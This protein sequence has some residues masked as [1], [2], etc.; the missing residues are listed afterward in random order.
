METDD[1]DAG[2]PPELTSELETDERRPDPIS[3]LLFRMLYFVCY[4]LARYIVLNPVRARMVERPEDYR[5]SSYRATV[6]LKAA[7]ESQN[8]SE[9]FLRILQR[10]VLGLVVRRSAVDDCLGKLGS[11]LENQLKASVYPSPGP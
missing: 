7:R 11:H 5:W 3:Y 9:R 6:G 4:E 2:L 1:Q 10:G 8:H